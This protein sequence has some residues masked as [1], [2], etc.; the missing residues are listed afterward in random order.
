MK[1]LHVITSSNFGG[2]EQYLLHLIKEQK[3]KGHHITL[4]RHPFGQRDEEASA[5]ADCDVVTRVRNSVSPGH[6]LKLCRLIR[7]EGIDVI[8][9]H[10]AKASILGGV[11]GR[12]CRRPVIATVHGMNPGKD[13][14]FSTALIAVSRAV[15]EYLETKGRCRKTI[16][17]VHSGIPDPGRR[18]RV[19][20]E[21]G[22]LRLLFAGR[23]SREKGIDLLIPRLASLSETPWTLTLAG[24]GEMKEELLSLC[25]RL[26]IE[27]RVR[28]EGFVPDMGP[29]FLD[30]DCLVLPSRKE[31]FGL[32]IIEAFARGVPVL[33]SATGGI[34]EIITPESGGLLYDPASETSFLGAYQQLLSR[35]HLIRL[36]EL[37]YRSYRE[38]FTAEI[39]TEKVMK[40]Y[41]QYL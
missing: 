31:G 17:V 30:H 22:T 1:I 20:L 13:Y 25:R 28:F 10:L 39:M 33:A 37:A 9:T 21:E 26:Q 19:F 4:Y 24:E 12:L 6:L 40:V 32:V 5:L 3:K 34:T 16:H 2:A 23:L 15:K 14:R 29:L 35:D 11:A 27:E 8:H 18:K 36:G 41:G 38:H 7:R